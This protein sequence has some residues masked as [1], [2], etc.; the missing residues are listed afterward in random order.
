MNKITTSILL[1]A[2]FFLLIW[3]PSFAEPGGMMR[4]RG[5]GGWGGNAPYNQMY[6]P[7]TI[8]TVDGEVISVDE[9]THLGPQWYLENQDI[10]IQPGDK[11]EI[12]GSRVTF[13]GQPAIVAAQVKKGK[14]I[15]TLRDENGF[16]LWSGCCRSF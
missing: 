6:N 16:P 10:Q 2:S 13:S 5:S 15:L 4:W 11:V 8:E 3:E 14:T 1:I 12:T 7:K 9:I